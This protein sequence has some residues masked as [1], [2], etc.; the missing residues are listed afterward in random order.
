MPGLRRVQGVH[1]FYRKRQNF[2]EKIQ[3]KA[4][5]LV[6]NSILKEKMTFELFWDSLNNL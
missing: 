4:K 3:F 6:T 5:L 2:E 1:K